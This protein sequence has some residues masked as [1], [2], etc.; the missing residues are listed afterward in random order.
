MKKLIKIPL[1]Y[2]VAMSVFL[3]TCT[4][5]VLLDAFVLSSSAIVIDEKPI[6]C[7]DENT[8]VVKEVDATTDSYT[9]SATSTTIYKSISIEIITYEGATLY[10]ADIKLSNPQYLRSAFAK[11]TYGKNIRQ[12]TS[13]I[14]EN[15]N[16]IL[17]INGDYYGYRSVGM[18]IRNGV[19]YRDVPRT[20]A[21]TR[22]L[23]IDDKGNFEIFE[24]GSETGKALVDRGIL[25]AWSFGP[26]L[27]ENGEIATADI[28]S[29][30]WVSSSKNPRVGIAQIGPLHYMFI[31]ADGRSTLS[32]GVNLT[33][34]AQVFKDRGAK[35]AYNLDGGGSATIWFNGKVIN[36]PTYDGQG[37]YERG[38]SDIVYILGNQE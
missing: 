22:A 29:Q 32:T 3:T 28:S 21:D 36:K 25:Q 20:G 24:E 31:V 10:I 7:D 27:V 2:A 23:L 16:A 5:F 35:I 12:Y 14:A 6:V 11:D 19:L 37:V 1:L 33:Q 17:A 9:E 15:H 8:D 18:V 30:N 38:V 34:L 4:A 13:D 26:V